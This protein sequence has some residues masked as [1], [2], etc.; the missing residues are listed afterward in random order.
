MDNITAL[1]PSM[2]FDAGE[3]EAPIP[4]QS[5]EPHLDHQPIAAAAAAAAADHGLLAVRSDVRDGVDGG[6]PPPPPPAPD[7]REPAIGMEFESPEAA[8]AFYAGYAE[9]AG[10][11]VRNSKSF[12]S[13]VDDSVIMRRFVCSKQGR[14]TKKDPFDLTKKR[15]NR[16]SSREGCKAMLQ[17]NRRDTGRWAVSRCL[18]DHCHPLGASFTD[19]PPPAAAAAAAAA[20][21]QKKLS[22]KPWE[23]LACTPAESHSHQNGLGPGGG[24]AQSLLEYFKKMQAENPAFFY[25]IQLDRNNCVQNVFWADGRARMSY[26]YFGD[27]VVFDTTCRKNKRLVPFAAFTGMNHHRQMIVFGCAFMTDESEDSFAWLFDTWLMLMSRQK[28]ASFTTGY[29]EAVEAAARKVLPDVRHRFCKRDVF[30]KSK[31]KLADVYSAHPSFKAELKKCVGESESVEEFESSWNS[32]IER[33]DLVEN[34][35]LLKLYSIRHKWVPVFFK[36][37]F[38]GEFSGGTK[39]E[40]MQK[41]FQR[42]S[43]TTTTLRDLVTQFDKAMAGQYEKEIQ[44]D[45]AT[46][47]T[48]PV[49]KTPSPLEKQAS[50]I[51]TKTIFELFQDELV[52]TSGFLTEKVDDGVTSIFRVIKVEDSS[53]THVVKYNDS[54]KSIIC[55][56]CK[57]EFSGILCR[58]VFR[59]MMVLSILSLPDSYILKRWTRNAKSDAVSLIPSNCKKPLNW[60]SNDL[61]RDA[62]K[63]AE[64]GATSAAIYKVAKGALQKAFAEVLASKKGC[65]FNGSR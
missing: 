27:S 38:F 1:A 59:V 28:P 32:L 13:R 19:K 47:H 21:S 52:E 46:I 7:P 4:I 23:L 36:D 34:I 26:S 24:V 9:R 18:L 63:F 29:S 12:T 39:L 60:R 2:G 64:E 40:T 3:V 20:A 58:H 56:C 11:R 8:R 65:S 61:F 55:S 45:F 53:K 43:I 17:V 44:A 42:H 31:E 48:R 14:P 51:Y 41:F 54:E 30:S 50:D 35:W 37:K 49:M 33:Y 15:R 25:S 6:D 5:Q 10:F 16:A 22:K 57:F 62:I